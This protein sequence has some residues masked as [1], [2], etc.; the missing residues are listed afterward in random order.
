M[1]IAEVTDPV[2]A[3][4]INQQYEYCQNA[5]DL[6]NC[7]RG[8]WRLNRARAEEAEY[9]FAVYQSV[10]KE[11]YEI[12]KWVPVTKERSDFWVERLR[13]QGRI[14]SPLEHEGRSDFIGRVASDNVRKKYVGKTMPVRQGQNPIRYFNC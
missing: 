4:C 2:I 12:E 11:V 14:I 7:T 5:S 3:I 6:Y 1:T 10:I 9:A 8:V 13:S